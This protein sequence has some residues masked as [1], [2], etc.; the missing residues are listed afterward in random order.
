MKVE[1]TVAG[2]GAEGKGLMAQEREERNRAPSSR[3]YR[4]ERAMTTPY[5]EGQAG[6]EQPSPTQAKKLE[7][8][9]PS[10]SRAHR[11][12]ALNSQ[13]KRPI[14]TGARRHSRFESPRAAPQKERPEKLYQGGSFQGTRR[15]TPR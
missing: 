7:A 10:D 3:F 4:R 8:P 11:T 2:E 5:E 6:R 13:A 9:T 12:R 14:Q 1:E 15:P